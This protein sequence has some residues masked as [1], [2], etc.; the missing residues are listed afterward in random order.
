[1]ILTEKHYRAE[2]GNCAETY[3]SF[4]AIVEVEQD[5]HYIRVN[6]DNLSRWRTV[7]EYADYLRWVADEVETLV[8]E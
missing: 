5:R 6:I 3:Q 7:K 4:S 1:M 2:R 8:V